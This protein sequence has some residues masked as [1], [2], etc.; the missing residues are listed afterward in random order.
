MANTVNRPFCTY[1]KKKDFNPDTVVFETLLAIKEKKNS[2]NI[3]KNAIFNSL[4]FFS[5]FLPCTGRDTRMEIK[6][7]IKHWRRNLKGC[8]KFIRIDRLTDDEQDRIRRKHFDNKPIEHILF[9]K[10]NTG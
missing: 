8:L 5:L 1:E 10:T 7:G 9:T 6:K 3:F 4:A 2:D